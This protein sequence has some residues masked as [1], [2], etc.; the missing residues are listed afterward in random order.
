MNN[1]DSAMGFF[2]LG[3]FVFIAIYIY[4]LCDI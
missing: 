4:F 2:T 1:L 3:I